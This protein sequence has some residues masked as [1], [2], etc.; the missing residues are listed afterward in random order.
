MVESEILFVAAT[1]WMKPV[2]HGLGSDR[3]L[4]G[5][6]PLV[7]TVCFKCSWGF[8][9]TLLRGRQL[10]EEW[11]VNCRRQWCGSREWASTRCLTSSQ[12]L[13]WPTATARVTFTSICAEQGILISTDRWRC[14]CAG[15]APQTAAGLVS[16]ASF[17][18][19]EAGRSTFT[20]PGFSSVRRLTAP[21]LCD[22]PVSVRAVVSSRA[23]SERS[24]VTR[25]SLPTQ[26]AHMRFH[27]S[28]GVTA[29]KESSWTW[30]SFLVKL[31]A[32]VLSFIVFIWKIPGIFTFATLE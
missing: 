8:F 5:Q 25:L 20:A 9:P 7:S 2:S 27:C 19:R 23:V 26:S 24:S 29:V 32:T 13:A 18:H 3:A 30:R 22:T 11:P 21:F 14:V 4:E 1:K 28:K 12:L 31:N 6:K 17:H 16:V 10:W 15:P